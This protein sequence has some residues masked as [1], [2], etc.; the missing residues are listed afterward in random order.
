MS[1]TFHRHSHYFNM[2]F[3]IDGFGVTALKAWSD[4]VMLLYYSPNY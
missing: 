4:E 2:A 3:V 1:S